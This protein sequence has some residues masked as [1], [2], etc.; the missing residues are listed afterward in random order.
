ME[1]LDKV[2]E[3]LNHYIDKNVAFFTSGSY[4]KNISSIID[5]YI[6]NYAKKRIFY[7]NNIPSNFEIKDLQN[8]LLFFKKNNIDIIFTVGG[9]SVIDFGKLV[10][11]FGNNNISINDWIRNVNKKV[12]TK[13]TNSLI[14]IPTTFGSGSEATKFAVLY[15]GIKKYSIEHDF[16]LPH[17]SIIDE[18]FSKT[19]S[20]FQAAVS[21]IDAMCQSIESIWAVGANDESISYASEALS[22]ISSNIVEYVNCDRKNADKIAL[23]SYLAGKA[24]NISKTTASHALSYAITKLYNIPHGQ[25]VS[26]TIANLMKYN[27]QN[28]NHELLNISID[29]LNNRM[30]ILLDSIKE[31]TIK[32]G[33][34]KIKSII[35]ETGMTVDISKFDINKIS[36]NVNIE[37]LGNNPVKILRLDD[38][39]IES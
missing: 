19:L 30:A 35:F 31:K 32:D 34:K 24:I 11:F 20:N 39:F 4:E 37:R 15:D 26:I 3:L 27:F 13:N 7:Y 36:Q 5:P 18:V 8:G 28:N 25:A 14:A 22:L 21:A 10:N 17:I 9:G 2:T 38:I 6:P 16:I 12:V 23:G 33:I 29:K 1:K